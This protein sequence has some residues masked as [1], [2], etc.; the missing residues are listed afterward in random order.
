MICSTSIRQEASRPALRL[1]SRCPC[2]SAPSLPPAPPLPAA[3]RHSPCPPAWC[4]PMCQLLSWTTVLFQVLSWKTKNGFCLCLSFCIVSV[5]SVTKPLQCRAPQLTLSQAP[6]LSA[7][8]TS[9]LWEQNSSARRGLSWG[10]LAGVDRGL[11]CRPGASGEETLRWT[12]AEGAAMEAEV[13]GPRPQAKAAPS[14]SSLGG[15]A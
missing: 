14:C 12:P 13:E 2:R 4:Q 11:P 8:L 1:P 7:G 10:G 3:V 9:V 5:K 6:G 15:Q